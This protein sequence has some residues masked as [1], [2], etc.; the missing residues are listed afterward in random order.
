MRL[1]MLAVVAAQ[2]GL[3]QP[4]CAD[5]PAEADLSLREM[6]PLFEKNHCTDIKDPAGQLFCGDP[7]LQSAAVRLS[8]A[9]QDRL[10]RIAD[11]R[12]AVEENVEDRK[13]VV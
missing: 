4:V 1:I 5:T 13:S 3:M 6:L 12:L 10:G 7:K 11:R 2:V 9:V 8:S